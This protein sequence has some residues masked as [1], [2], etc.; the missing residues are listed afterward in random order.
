ELEQMV[1][2]SLFYRINR[3]SIVALSSIQKMEPYLSN[4]LLLH[5][6]PEPGSEQM[7][8]SRQRVK[9]FKEWIDQ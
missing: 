8:V 5:V 3:G 4:R 2:P 1:D 9:A 6:D 7:V